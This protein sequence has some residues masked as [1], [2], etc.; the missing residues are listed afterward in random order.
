MP[1]RYNFACHL[2]FILEIMCSLK[3]STQYFMCTSYIRRFKFFTWSISHISH[4]YRT[5]R[6]IDGMLYIWF[7][8]DCDFASRVF[9]WKWHNIFV[10]IS[11]TGRIRAGLA[12]KRIRNG[13]KFPFSMF[14]RKICRQLGVDAVRRPR[15]MLLWPCFILPYWLDSMDQ[16]RQLSLK[17]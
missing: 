7:C 1:T 5:I 13:H 6:T 3:P 8:G 14:I 16:S 15:Q 4:S 11:I 9:Y 17:Q 12:V 10:V 2:C